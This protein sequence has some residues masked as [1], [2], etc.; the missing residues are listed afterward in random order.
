MLLLLSKSY[1]CVWDL[2]FTLKEGK[3]TWNSPNNKKIDNQKKTKRESGNNSL[4]SWKETKR[5]SG[6]NGLVN[7]R[8]V[9]IGTTC[10]SIRRTRNWRRKFELSFTFIFFSFHPMFWFWLR[11]LF[12][13]NLCS[14]GTLRIWMRLTIVPMWASTS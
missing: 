8:I 9:G 10:S 5:E 13:L 6:N 12:I 7:E 1:V 4:V 14:S 2:L 11:L 3:E